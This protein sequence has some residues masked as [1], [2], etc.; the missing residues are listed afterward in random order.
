[1]WLYHFIFPSAMHVISNCSVSLSTLDTVSL[2]LFS[3]VNRYVM[4][5]HW[6]FNLHFHERQ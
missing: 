4:L 6:G 5:S 2:F 1:M 3:L